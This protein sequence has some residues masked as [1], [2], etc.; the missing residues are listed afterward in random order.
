VHDPLLTPIR[1]RRRRIQRV[2]GGLAV[3]AVVAFV[4]AL[5]R[6]GAG[7]KAPLPASPTQPKPAPGAPTINQV[8]GFDPFKY[9]PERDAE[10]LERGREGLAHVLYAKSPGGI[11][12]SADRTARYRPWIE[13]AA[14]RHLVDPNT[15]EAIVLLESAGR[16]DIEAAG[17]PDSAVGLAQI[18]PGTATDLLGMHVDLQRSLRIH[19]RLVREGRI[20][21]RARKQRTRN[22]A[23]K[24]IAA[25]L[26]L[27]PK[28]DQRYDPRASLEGAARYLEFAQGELGRLDLA[29]ASYHMGV[30]NVQTVIDTYVSP[31]PREATTAATVKR[32][33]ITYPR[34][35]F[36]ST[37]LR[38]PKAYRRL[39]ALGD[40]S[41]YYLF[42]V[43]AAR[44]IMDQSRSKDGL[45]KLR[46]TA[47]L[48]V[49]KASAENLLRPRSEN[50]PFKD[51]TALRRAYR[52][53]KLVALPDDPRRLGYRI[54]KGMGSLARKVKER[55]AL[56]RG[57]RPESLAVLVYLTT[58]VRAAAGGSHLIV[59]ST[60]R[61]LKYQDALVGIN[62]QATREYS[63]HT[64]G[65]AFDIE[66]NFRSRAEAA[67]TVA[68]LER[69]RAL[70]LIDWVYEPT[71][72]HVTAGP[73]AKEL[74]PLLDKLIERP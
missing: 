67:A 1:A 68:T 55:K 59:T 71:A 38:N 73:R 18:L 61:D 54:D 51:G 14:K 29:T 2:A 20:A 64:V 22:R 24:A 47:A 56:F 63:L 49:Q 66:R 5:S 58:Q 11:E 69:L 4:F 52:D 19:Q 74:L 27:R 43:E 57:L 10:F 33:G 34:L 36:D 28:V 17:N 42:K 9:T 72:L 53:G 48:Q 40:D 45:E 37:P 44:Q 50:E 8:R 6:A 39:T 13:Q 35:Y 7:D 15:I 60:V 25:L 12:A 26:A 16:P 62:T 21:A 70:N 3:L 23:K 32:Y 46:A 30:G 31:H 65:Y 41:R